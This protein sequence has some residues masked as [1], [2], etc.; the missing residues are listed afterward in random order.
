MTGNVTAPDT[1]LPGLYGWVRLAGTDW[2]SDPACCCILAEKQC[3]PTLL[4]LHSRS[5]SP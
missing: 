3:R 2:G 1:V 4:K 5:T